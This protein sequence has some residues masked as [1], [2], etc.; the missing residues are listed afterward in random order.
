MSTPADDT[1][2]VLERGAAATGWNE[3]SQLDVALDFIEERSPRTFGAFLSRQALDEGAGDVPAPA[4]Q[5]AASAR[6]LVRHYAAR[7]GWDERSQL[8]LA[9]RFVEETLDPSE[10]SAYVSGRV[11]AEQELT[12]E[13]P[14]P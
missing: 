5:G 2:T 9:G 8:A 4:G 13:A 12:A 6:E 7:T 1:R 11:A 14:A 10:F 3:M